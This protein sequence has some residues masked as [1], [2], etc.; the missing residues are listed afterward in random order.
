[1]KVLKE[2]SAHSQLQTVIIVPTVNLFKNLGRLATKIHVN[3]QCVVTL[4]GTVISS[5]DLVP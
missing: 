5:T 2:A 4:P 3:Y 1:M